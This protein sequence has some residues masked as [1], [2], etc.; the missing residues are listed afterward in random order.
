MIDINRIQDEAD[1]FLEWPSNDHS[2][3]T[4]TSMI[5]FCK[6]MIDI[7]VVEEREEFLEYIR[8]RK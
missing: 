8:S 3:V 6:H 5:L 2:I 1:S 7:A 4:I